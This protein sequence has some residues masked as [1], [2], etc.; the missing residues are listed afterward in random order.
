MVF[1]FSVFGI[2]VLVKQR[3]K[4]SVKIKN[5]QT[6]ESLI[7]ILNSNICVFVAFMF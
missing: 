7:T 5:T 3:Y 4:F 1:V 2:V 6:F